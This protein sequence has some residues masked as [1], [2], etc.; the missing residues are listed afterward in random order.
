MSVLYRSDAARAL[1]WSRFFAT[2][3]PEIEFRTWPDD[4]G[5]LNDVEYLVSWHADAGFLASLPNLKVLF[6]SGAGI[7]HIDF[8]AVPEHVTV[9]RMVEPGIVNGM[10]EYVTMSVLALHR[11]LLDYIDSQ[12]RAEWRPIPVAPASTRTVGVMGLGVLGQAVLERLGI[13]GFRRVGWN[14][15]RKALDGVECF[16]GDESLP[17][18]LAQ[19]DL[20]VCLLPLTEATRGILDERLMSL[21]PRGAALINVARGPH[22]DHDALLS[23]LNSG[24]LSRAI[25]DVTDPEPLPPDHALWRHPRVLITPHIAS[26]TQPDTAAPVLLAN[27]RRHIAGEPLHDV[28]DRQRGY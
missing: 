11:N 8:N 13:F 26:M 20:L 27:L 28:V 5:D 6:A 23:A 15:S 4:I 22:L 2:H 10:V 12:S 18:F 9:V 24:H 19:C 16:A 7:D 1:A 25:L 14:R 17:R 3:A 21:L